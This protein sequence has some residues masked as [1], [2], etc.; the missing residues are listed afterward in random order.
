LKPNDPSAVISFGQSE[1]FTRV[2]AS[3]TS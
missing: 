2:T 3:V 1:T